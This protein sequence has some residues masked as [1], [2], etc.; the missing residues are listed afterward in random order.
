[1]WLPLALQGVENVYTQHTPALVSL[2]E[3]LAKAKLPDLD[4][5]RVD[6]HSSPQAPRVRMPGLLAAAWLLL[7]LLAPLACTP[8]MCGKLGPGGGAF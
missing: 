7:A 1:M 2:L 5:P 6:R 3:R 4:Y 8:R